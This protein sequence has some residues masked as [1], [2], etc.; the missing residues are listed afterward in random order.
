MKQ[1]VL[2]DRGSAIHLLAYFSSS[3]PNIH[4]VNLYFHTGHTPVLFC[5][6]DVVEFGAH[7]CRLDACQIAVCDCRRLR[8]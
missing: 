3:L 5:R 8:F 7:A 6:V 1:C 4:T 2:G